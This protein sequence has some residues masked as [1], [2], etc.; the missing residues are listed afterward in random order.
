MADAPDA[1]LTP[2]EQRRWEQAKRH[3]DT[4]RRFLNGSD[5]DGDQRKPLTDHALADLIRRQREPAVDPYTQGAGGRG[6]DVSNPTLSAVVRDAGGRTYTDP[7]TGEEIVTEDK[8]PT[9]PDPVLDAINELLGA[10]AEAAGILRVADTRRQYIDSIPRG[11]I[12]SLAGQC[13]ACHRDVAGGTNDPLRSGY[14]DACRK[15]WDRAGKP[16]RAAF[17]ATRQQRAS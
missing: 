4:I 9:T 5:T 8:W 10:L 15:A 12:S 1:K 16:D 7:I 3:R 17:E 2:P 11:R 13:Q 14:C 6:N